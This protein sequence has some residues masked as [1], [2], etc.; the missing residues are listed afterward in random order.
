MHPE[1]GMLLPITVIALAAFAVVSLVQSKFAI[2]VVGT[3]LPG[4][5]AA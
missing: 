3:Y 5:T 1:A 4:G 2:P